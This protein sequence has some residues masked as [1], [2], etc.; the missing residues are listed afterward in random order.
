MAVGKLKSYTNDKIRDTTALITE[1]RDSL[2]FIETKQMELE[3]DVGDGGAEVENALT[4]VNFTF[5]CSY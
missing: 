4:D 3:K 5:R 2:R 1:V